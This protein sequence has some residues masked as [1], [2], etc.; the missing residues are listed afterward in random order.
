MRLMVESVSLL[1]FSLA[2]MIGLDD[3]KIELCSDF[4]GL[5]VGW[6]F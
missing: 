2:R 4:V 6:F 5:G 3:E 1:S